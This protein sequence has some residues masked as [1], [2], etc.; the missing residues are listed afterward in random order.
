MERLE[1]I[2]RD[3][4]LDGA[5]VEVFAYLAGK[6]KASLDEIY[7]ETALSRR[8]ISLALGELESA[9]AVR[10]DGPAFAIDDARKSLQALLPA[11]FEELK[12]EIYS[13]RP[14]MRK[15][16]CP[17]VETIRDEATAV[18]AF[19]GNRIDAALKSVDM[20]SRSLTWI[21]DY[22]LGAARAAVQRG[23]RVRV[24]TY[25]HP[26][27]LA[28][29]RALTDAGAEVRSH[30]YSKD[31]RFMIIDGEFVSFAIKEPP[32]VTQ[33]AYFGL[34]IRDKAVCRNMLEYIFDPAW[35]DAE[36]VEKYR[37]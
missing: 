5:L 35:E 24:I 20:I 23:V 30:E 17:L 2:L 1:K 32:R 12:A 29:A 13:Y 4:G 8:A 25:K 18:P 14:V 19:T 6:G 28:D 26:E 31:V 37:I 22:S 11:R 10:K 7:D 34:L 3:L 21:D 9:G 33:P 15:E 16:E 36:V 27:L